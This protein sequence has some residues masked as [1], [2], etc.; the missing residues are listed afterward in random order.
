[1]GEHDVTGPSEEERRAFSQALL[2]DVRA[3]E[4]MIAEGRIETGVRRIGA[5]QELFLVNPSF[6]AHCVADQVLARLKGNFTP[7]L[8]RFNVE[9]NA[10]PQLLTGDCLGAMERELSGMVAEVERAAGEVGSRAVLCGILPTLHQHELGLDAM[11]QEPRY[12]ALN[13]ILSEMRGSEF[14]AHIKGLDELR[15]THD[16]VMLEAC[17]TSF[18]LHFQTGPDEFPFLYNLAQVVIAPVLAC[19][20]N[21]PV[22]LQ[23]RLWHE[24]RVAL[25]QQSL[26]ARNESQQRRGSRR[27]VTF[28]AGWVQKSVLEIF[29]EDVARFRVLLSSDLGESSLAML[30]RGEIPPLKALCLFNG[31]V[32]RWNRPCYG[33]KDG[34]AHLRIESRAFPAGP[35]VLD[36]MAGAA[37]YFGLMVALGETLGDVRTKMAFDDARTNF[38]AAAR[39]GLDAQFRWVEGEQVPARALILERLLPMA[40]EGLQEK[41]IDP[42]DIDRYLG[43]VEERVRSGRT[44]AKWALDSLADMGGRGTP[45]SRHRALTAAMYAGQHTDEP[46]HKWPLAG[47]ETKTDW[48]HSYRTV[49][50]VMTRDVFTVG[51]EDVVDLVASL[52]DWEHLHRVPVEDKDGRLVGMISQRSLLRVLAQRTLAGRAVAVREIMKPTPLITVEPGASTLDAIELMRAHK[53]GSLPVVE[54]DRLVGIVTEHDFIAVAAKLLEESLRGA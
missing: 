24:T 38:L 7:E 31:T 28:G 1:M 32:Y 37:L 8:A 10:S 51:P 19:S 11:V 43:V 14:T 54:G 47:L 45:D 46:V 9:A 34:K 25:F 22:F 29:R 26:D 52:M 4:R 50:Q 6:E 49:R 2:E 39:Y 12:L 18:Q 41:R 21:S 40:R 27:R 5:E 13:Q 17:N 35:T 16:N 30:D 33:V 48:R 44:G 42:G 15:V 23:H 3:L 20:V 36:E 53:V